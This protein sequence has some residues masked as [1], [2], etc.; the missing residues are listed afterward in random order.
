MYEA[1]TL[2]DTLE[3]WSDPATA[4]ER[5]KM[6]NRIYQSAAQVGKAL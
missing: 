5:I 1:R 4:H 6:G 3:T 2:Y